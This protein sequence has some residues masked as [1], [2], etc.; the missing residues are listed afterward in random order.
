MNYKM[1]ILK[2]II[3]YFDYSIKVSHPFFRIGRAIRQA[4]N[5]RKSMVKAGTSQ[6]TLKNLSKNELSDTNVIEMNIIEDLVPCHNRQ[7]ELLETVQAILITHPNKVLYD[8]RQLKTQ[9]S[10][11][12]QEVMITENE[13]TP[14]LRKRSMVLYRSNTIKR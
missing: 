12:T 8:R 14:R 3:P 4:R 6:Y 13:E 5:R 9:D 7:E 11:A 2:Q 1:Y 10:A